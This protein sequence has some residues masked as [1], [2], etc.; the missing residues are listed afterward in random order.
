M[1]TYPPRLDKER[2]VQW[3]RNMADS[4]EIGEFVLTREFGVDNASD[5]IKALKLKRMAPT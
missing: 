2:M 1:K 5:A 3:L 4:V